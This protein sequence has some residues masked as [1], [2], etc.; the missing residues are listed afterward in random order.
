MVEKGKIVNIRTF[1][2]Q[3]YQDRYKSSNNFK[4]SQ[5]KIDGKIIYESQK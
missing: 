3:K 4:D 5:K 2:K 1:V